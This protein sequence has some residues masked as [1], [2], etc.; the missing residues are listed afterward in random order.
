MM[1][2]RNSSCAANPQL[3]GQL[4]HRDPKDFQKSLVSAKVKT[5]SYRNAYANDHNI[6]FLPAV[7]ST[8]GH[9][10]CELLRILLL[11]AHRETEEC[12]ECSG[13]PAQYDSDFF[14]FKR[15][16]FYGAIKSKAGLSFA[17]AAVMRVFSSF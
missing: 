13:L 1:H 2:L 14:K 9:V 5:D 8:S 15:A 3:N 4:C 12:F 16:A 7:T 6:S 17:K 10:H 11:Q